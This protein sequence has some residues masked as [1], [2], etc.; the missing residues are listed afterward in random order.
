MS[1][2]AKHEVRPLHDVPMFVLGQV[3]V[4]RPMV[5]QLCS[6]CSGYVETVR[7]DDGQPEERLT[8]L[9]Y[10]FLEVVQAV[11][12][13]ALVEVYDVAGRHRRPT[14]AHELL[15]D[16]AY[17]ASKLFAMLSAALAG[18]GSHPNPF[19]VGWAM[20]DAL[21]ELEARCKSDETREAVD[22]V[23]DG[24]DEAALSELLRA[25]GGRS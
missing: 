5:E 13:N 8:E 4:L 16:L 15:D 14:P 10:G 24:S 23:F 18:T 19:L 20:G 22:K 11:A 17:D 7:A 25:V 2:S 3:E 1:D 6:D 12:D 21:R 9:G